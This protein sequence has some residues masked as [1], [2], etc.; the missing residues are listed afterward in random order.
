MRHGSTLKKVLIIN[1]HLPTTT[2]T[3]FENF[4]KKKQ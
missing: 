2:T 3:H 1:P 4:C